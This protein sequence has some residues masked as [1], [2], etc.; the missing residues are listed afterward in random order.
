MSINLL[1]NG[2]IVDT[3]NGDISI[4]ADGDISI[5][6]TLLTDNIKE[7]KR[8]S[9]TPYVDRQDDLVTKN[10]IRYGENTKSTVKI[11]PYEDGIEIE[12]STDD[13]QI[14]EYGINLP[15]NFMGKKNG[16]GWRKQYLFNSP[17]MSPDKKIIYAYLTNPDG[18]H[19]LVAILSEADGWKMD[20]S[21]FGWAHYFINL[22][23][24]ANYK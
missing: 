4:F 5:C 15:F 17:Y 7:G 3:R 6:Y 24:L 9:S 11:A 21:P 18:N 19:L 14:S 2:R 20:Y 22:K 8:V 13:C 12:A 10:L 1:E 16:G 23:L